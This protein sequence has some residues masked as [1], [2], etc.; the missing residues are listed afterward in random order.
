MSE[1]T[2]TYI[3][4]HIIYVYVARMLKLHLANGQYTQVGYRESNVFK[5]LVSRPKL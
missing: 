2:N 3:D 4:I 1:Y 5:V